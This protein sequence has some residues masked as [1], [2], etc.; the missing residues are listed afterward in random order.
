M[1]HRY[2]LS[3][4]IINEH[5]VKNNENNNFKDVFKTYYLDQK[6]KFNHFTVLIVFKM[7]NEVVN[8]IEVP[9]CIMVDTGVISC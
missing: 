6:K 1:R 8:K 9:S 5:I 2:F 7:N 3:N 4:L